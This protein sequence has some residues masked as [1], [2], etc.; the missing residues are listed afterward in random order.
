MIR[1]YCTGGRGTEKFIKTE[2]EEKLRAQNIVVSDGKVYFDANI[3]QIQQIVTLRSVERIFVHI[4]QLDW[5]TIRE[6]NK[7]KQYDRISYVHVRR[8]I[9]NADIWNDPVIHQIPHEVLQ[10]QN[11][12]MID[13]SSPD[14]K[15]QSTTTCSHVLEKTSIDCSQKLESNKPTTTNT[16]T[17]VEV[18]NKEGPSTIEK[19][20][21]PMD[22]QNDRLD[23][24]PVASMETNKVDLPIT[25]KKSISDD[26]KNIECDKH[27]VDSKEPERLSMSVTE[28]YDPLTETPKS[29][30]ESGLLKVEQSLGSTKSVKRSCSPNR[31]NPEE[32]L[33]KKEKLDFTFRVT[34]RC[35]GLVG[36]YVYA[37]DL[38]ISIG[39]KLKNMLNWKVNLRDPDIEISCHVNDKCVVLGMPIMRLP[40]SN[41]SYIKHF[42]LRST[43]SYIMSSL[44]PLKSGDIVLDPMC[45]KAT[46]LVESAHENKSITYIGSDKDDNQIKF[47]TDNIRFAK[48]ENVQIFKG[49]VLEMPLRNCSIDHVL[50]DAP[51]GKQYKVDCDLEHFYTRFLNEV[52]RILKPDGIV[53]LLTSP[54]MERFLLKSLSK[55][56]KSKQENVIQEKDIKTDEKGSSKRTN[57]AIRSRSEIDIQKGDNASLIEQ[58][59][60]LQNTN[61]DLKGK[62]DIEKEDNSSKISLNNDPKQ[63]NDIEMGDNPSKTDNTAMTSKKNDQKQESDIKMGDNSLKIHQQ[64][65]SNLK[66]TV[67]DPNLGNDIVNPDRNGLE[68][69]KSNIPNTAIDEESGSQTGIEIKDLISKRHH[70]RILANATGR[71]ADWVNSVEDSFVKD[72]LLFMKLLYVDSHYMKLG[73]T[74]AYICILHKSIV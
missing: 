66:S 18:L 6:I 29:E 16:D 58:Q 63:E 35:T 23:I 25:E 4:L 56:K 65:I 36:K 9:M 59:D 49:S 45:G 44:L 68:K 2:L 48:L 17:L 43:I 5:K 26:V 69:E 50:C 27:D 55:K 33:K 24:Q 72:E 3:S 60:D 34:C 1:F 74:H 46:I 51:F 14:S 19:Q 71:T 37:Q 41:R 13:E 57:N 12:A 30:S 39:S 20:N 53:V 7:K 70:N 28:K 42:G 8:A 32:P 10:V 11:T 67:D 64:D 21:E 47:A 38:Q 40:L 15:H 22:I 62:N 31:E 61:K 73:E 52:T 54:E